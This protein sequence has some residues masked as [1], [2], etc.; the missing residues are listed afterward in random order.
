[1]N[2]LQSLI[3]LFQRD[4]VALTPLLF[5]LMFMFWRM[6][7]RISMLETILKSVQE[8]LIQHRKTE[9]HEKRE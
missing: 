3:D 5:V 1:M 7:K 9:G 4:N 8:N 2:D 6:D